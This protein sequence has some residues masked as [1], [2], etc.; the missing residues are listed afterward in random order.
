[1]S[2]LTTNKKRAWAKLVKKKPQLA[3]FLDEVSKDDGADSFCGY[4][5]WGGKWEYTGPPLPKGGS[6]T[7][8]AERIPKVLDFKC[9]EEGIYGK[10]VELFGMHSAQHDIAEEVLMSALPPCRNCSC[11]HQR[12][13][14]CASGA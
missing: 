9:V 6:F 13:R 10:L 11:R 5:V 4:E 14:K 7:R 12:W 1:M 2:N 3:D 8:I